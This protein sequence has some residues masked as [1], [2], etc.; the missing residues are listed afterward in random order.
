MTPGEIAEI[1][2]K[3]NPKDA[4]KALV[5]LA[6]DRGGPDNVTVQVLEVSA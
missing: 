5:Q 3:A 4:C 1:V 6:N 2:S